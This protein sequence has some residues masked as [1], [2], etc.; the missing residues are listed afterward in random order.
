MLLTRQ[1]LDS[2][3]K[4]QPNSA[5]SNIMETPLVCNKFVE[6]GCEQFTG[7]CDNGKCRYEGSLDSKAHSNTKASLNESM[8]E[9]LAYEI[10]KTKEHEECI[11]SLLSEFAMEIKRAAT[12]GN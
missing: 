4:N 9:D 12:E 6:E 5:W 10:G 2:K 11:K 7:R 1:K 3:R 8:V